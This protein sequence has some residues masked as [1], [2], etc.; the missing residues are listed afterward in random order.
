MVEIDWKKKAHEQLKITIQRVK[1][2][3][4]LKK[5]YSDLHKSLK[6]VTESRD[7]WK[8]MRLTL[9]EL[10]E[11]QKKE[12]TQLRK[13]LKEVSSSI[14]Y[15]IEDGEKQPMKSELGFLKVRLMEYCGELHT[16]NTRS[17]KE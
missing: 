5:M 3:H 8:Q 6:K 10:Y 7:S 4:A 16:D 13:K 15:I 11:V 1:E 2:I 14:N 17:E 9:D 12:N